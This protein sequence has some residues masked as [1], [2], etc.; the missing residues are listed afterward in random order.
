MGWFV[1]KAT[2]G[3]MEMIRGERKWGKSLWEATCSKHAMRSCI[4]K[5][6]DQ[7]CTV[8]K[9]L[10]GVKG[11]NFEEVDLMCTCLEHRVYML[12]PLGA[13][14]RTSQHFMEVLEQW[15]KN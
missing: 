3:D 13:D 2:A 5:S 12:H 15:V 4:R 11:L 14:P 8:V 6:S 7:S 1:H 10:L 9:C